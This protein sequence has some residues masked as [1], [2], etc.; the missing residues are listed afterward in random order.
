MFDP[1]SFTYDE[2][3]QGHAKRVDVQLRRVDLGLRGYLGLGVGA[4]R[5]EQLGRQVVPVADAGGAA[6]D[7]FEAQPEIA[8]FEKLFEFA[9]FFRLL[10][11]VKRATVTGFLGIKGGVPC[12]AS[13]G[14][15]AGK[16]G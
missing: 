7:P 14:L 8:Q 4:A 3:D 13:G 2:F 6:F 9:F 10:R 12:S 15:F 11:K 1:F 5:L 16:D